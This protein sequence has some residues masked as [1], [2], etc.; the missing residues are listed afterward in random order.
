[1]A[2]ARWLTRVLEVRK[3]RLRNARTSRG[4]P[5]VPRTVVIRTVVID[6]FYLGTENP[7]FAAAPSLGFVAVG[8]KITTRA[9]KRC[10]R[11]THFES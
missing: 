3:P 6:L 8:V 4:L 1:M 10:T 2:D 11:F 5:L 7:I 9:A